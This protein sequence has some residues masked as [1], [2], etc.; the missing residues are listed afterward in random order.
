MR[1]LH[2]IHWCCWIM[3][4]LT[5]DLFFP[6]WKCPFACV[7]CPV[8]FL[9]IEQRTSCCVS[10]SY[11]GKY[12]CQGDRDLEIREEEATYQFHG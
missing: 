7:E 9:R 11:I 12:F 1:S 5:A 4:I 8:L 6:L 2:H 3:C 10:V